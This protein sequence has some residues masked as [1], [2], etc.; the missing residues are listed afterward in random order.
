MI[1][2]KV[3]NTNQQAYCGAFYN[4]CRVIGSGANM[5]VP[6]TDSAL[7]QEYEE[8]QNAKRIILL[9]Y[10]KVEYIS[11]REMFDEVDKFL[12]TFKL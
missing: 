8:M 10:D 12:I 9:C 4:L 7:L 11:K 1:I 3:R 6:E 5:G 2:H